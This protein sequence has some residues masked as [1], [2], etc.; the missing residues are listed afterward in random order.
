MAKKGLKVQGEGEG[1]AEDARV[2]EDRTE[3]KKE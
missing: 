2:Q 3:A 1:K